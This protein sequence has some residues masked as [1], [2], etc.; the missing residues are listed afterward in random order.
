MAALEKRAGLNLSLRDAYI[1]IAGGI[2]MNEPAID[3]V[4]RSGNRLQFSVRLLFRQ[5]DRI[6]RG[7]T[8]RRG[9]RGKYAGT[10]GDGGAQTGIS[11][12]NSAQSMRIGG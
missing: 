5:Y 6:W 2:R 11:D 1:N 7:G 4:F 10:K 12:S 9:A 3:L 8:F